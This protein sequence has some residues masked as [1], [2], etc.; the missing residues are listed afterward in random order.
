M[1]EVK[2]L[3]YHVN[4]DD[5]KKCTAKKLKRFGYA[6]IINEIRR[7][8]RKVVVLNPLAEKIC[9]SLDKIYAERYGILAV[10]C[11]WEN[12]NEAFSRFKS[13]KN[14]R[15]LPFLIAVNP[16]NYGRPLR[17]STLEAFVAALYI[18]GKE[19]QAAK[20]SKIYKWSHHFIE[21]NRELLEKYQANRPQD[22]KNV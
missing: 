6:E 18:I 7:I 11:S 9:S 1:T 19:E 2:L 4:E 13:F 8:P 22:S 14:Q 21:I 10:D 20:I 16:V 3:I 17:L 15:A 5:P 12:V